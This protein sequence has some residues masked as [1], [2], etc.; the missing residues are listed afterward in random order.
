MGRYLRIERALDFW[1]GTLLKLAIIHLT[2]EISTGAYSTSGA[3]VRNAFRNYGSALLATFVYNVCVFVGLLLLVVPGL[4]LTVYWFFFLQAIVIHDKS[5]W[6]A[7]KH[8]GRLVTGRWWSFFARLLLLHVLLLA[9]I[10]ILAVFS[11]F[12]PESTLVAILAM[13]P[14]DLV[15]TFFYVCLTELFLK[16][17]PEAILEDEAAAFD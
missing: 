16:S 9:I 5:A 6:Q 1:I 17:D 15:A 7:L 13:I 8:S 10:G 2:Y 4:F 11:A 14:A 3:A 12:M